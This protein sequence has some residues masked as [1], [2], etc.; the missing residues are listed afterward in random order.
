MA[1]NVLCASIAF[2]LGI[3][4]GSVFRAPWAIAAFVLLISA[5]SFFCWLLRKRRAYLLVALCLC[6]FVLGHWRVAVVPRTIPEPFRQ[7]LE[8]EIALEGIVVA[9]PDVRETN[10]RVSIRVELDE[11][12]TTVLAVATLYPSVQYGERVLV[13][14]TLAA[15]EPFETDLGRTFAYDRF[16]A[17]DGIFAL[18]ENASIEKIGE[19]SGFGARA[20]GAL[21][22]ARQAFMRSLAR[23]LPEPDASLAAG[24]IAGGKQGLGKELLDAFI[25]SGLVHIV[26]LSGYN[27]MI[28]AEFIL[29][30]FGFL[31]KRI[32]AVLAGGSIAAFV[33]AAGAGSA[34]LRAGL[35]SGLAL[36][37][38][39][40]GRTY[41]VMRALLLA[42][43]LMLLGNP[44]LLTYDP[45]FQLSFIATAGLILGAPLLEAR[46]GFVRSAFW[47]EILAATIA[48]QAAV[49]PLLLYQTGL[50]SL[51]SLP[52]NLVVLPIVPLAMA[53]SAFAGMMGTLV[54]SFGTLFGLPAHFAL[55]Y[56]I[57]VVR[58][59]SSLPLA[60]VSIPAF[61][62]WLVMLL[63]AGLSFFVWNEDKNTLSRPGS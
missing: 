40:T 41:D 21:L 58:F 32:S 39:A 51:V 22:D 3:L 37:A 45:G 4:Y 43:V 61:P 50:F 14:G 56:I 42:A 12:I 28:V 55:S 9:D 2:V 46:L 13:R 11:A 63:Y 44:L 6:S 23:A 30:A 8:S 54:P 27:V 59:A 19:R 47:R 18:V 34:S 5:L 36:I 49:L 17:K 29:K 1:G 20:M 48:A 24:L 26:V 35:M 38:R 15:P 33:L 10:Q 25:V 7:F 52:A 62:F 60:S 53:L 31:P 16:L 57:E